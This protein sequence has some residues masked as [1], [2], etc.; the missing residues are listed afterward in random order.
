MVE[1]PRIG[2]L[3]WTHKRKQKIGPT[4]GSLESHIKSKIKL[5]TKE[6]ELK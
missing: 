1:K 3:T 6:M 4:L 5:I 2:V